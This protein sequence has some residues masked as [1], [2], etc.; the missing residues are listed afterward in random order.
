MDRNTLI[1]MLDAV[2]TTL[3]GSLE[4]LEK[5]AP[6]PQ[7]ALAWRP[8]P[9]RAHIAWQTMHCAATQDKYLNVFIRGGQARDPKMVE[10]FG[11]GSTPSDHNIPALG[12][13]R[14]ALANDLDPL[15]QFLRTAELDTVVG[16]PDR[17]RTIAKAAMMLA[18][19]E[20]HHQGQIH[21]TWNLFKQAH[22]IA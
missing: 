15:E 13:I 22:G 16:P 10:A 3:L 7:A 2:R 21:L 18:W 19:H 5:N 12:Q 1:E 20:A 14:D 4:V 17:R 8:A 9:D 6:D 11:G